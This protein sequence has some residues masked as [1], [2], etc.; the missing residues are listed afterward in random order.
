MVRLHTSKERSAKAWMWRLAIGPAS[1]IQGII[2]TLT[3]GMVSTNLTLEVTR[4]LALARI[5]ELGPDMRKVL[6]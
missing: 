3:F 2:S 5:K 4:Q 6:K 1:I